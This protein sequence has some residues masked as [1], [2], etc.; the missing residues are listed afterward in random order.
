MDLVHEQK[1]ALTGAGGIARGGEGGFQI[2]N[3]GKDGG[4]RRKA[5]LHVIGQKARERGL[6]GAGRS[7][8][9]HGRK[10]PRRHHAAN[11]AFGASQVI[12]PDDFIDRAGAE[13]I[14][15]G[16]VAGRFGRGG[17]RRQATEEI[18]H[19][20]YIGCDSRSCTGCCGGQGGSAYQSILHNW[21]KDIS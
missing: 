21:I 12:L 9:D 11:G 1:R 15:Q 8:Q 6:A 13:A 5:H 3:A 4:D 7:P 14:R 16:R 19:A 2:G 10:A 18:R 20:A 17:G